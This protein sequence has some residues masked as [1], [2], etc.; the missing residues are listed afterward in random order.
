M[1]SFCFLLAV[2]LNSI[3]LKFSKNLGK[4]NYA[5]SLVRW[6]AEQKPALGGISF[7]LTFLI[8]YSVYTIFFNINPSFIDVKN[9][10]ILMSFGVA[11]LMGLSDDA[12]NTKPLLKFSAQFA[13]GIILIATG[14]YITFFESEILNY[15]ITVLWVVGMMN[16][17]N[18]LDNMDGVATLISIFIIATLIIISLINPALPPD[19]FLLT[20]MVAVLASLLGFILFNWNPSKMFMGDTGSQFLGVF[21]AATGIIYLWNFKP[22]QGTENIFQ[23][24]I[25]LLL[26]FIVPLVDTITVS[27]NRPLR[28]QSPFVG[29][30]DHTTHHLSYLGFSDKKVAIIVGAIGLFSGALVVAIAALITNWNWKLT[31]IFGLYFCGVFFILYRQTQKNKPLKAIK[32]ETTPKKPYREFIEN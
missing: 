4:R 27:I 2:L 25:M 3:L 21:L 28:G 32:H 15:I 14:T 8:S 7:Y 12:Y 26:T 6:S 20:S 29:G 9:L 10:G 19:S 31:L 22:I 17:I 13:C 1:F 24:I 16:S 5:E 30:K 11:F 18:M 23:Q